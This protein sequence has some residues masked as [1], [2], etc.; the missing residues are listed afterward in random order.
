MVFSRH[1]LACAIPHAKTLMTL[2]CGLRDKFYDTYST[3]L[4]CFHRCVPY[5]LFLDFHF[6]LIIP[7]I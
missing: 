1:E 6:W 4:S 2:G 3:G 7:N 5:F